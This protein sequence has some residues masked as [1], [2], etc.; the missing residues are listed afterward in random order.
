MQITHKTLTWQD[1]NALIEAV[2]ILDF[3]LRSMGCTLGTWAVRGSAV[4]KLQSAIRYLQA[5]IA[6]VR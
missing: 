5:Q 1:G 6:E 2:C 3:A 4:H